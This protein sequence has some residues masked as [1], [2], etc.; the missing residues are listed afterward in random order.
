M[1]LLTTLAFT[2][3]ICSAFARQIPI[4]E[5]KEYAK[6]FLSSRSFVLTRGMNDAT[7]KDLNLIE[8][9]A[10]SSFHAFNIGE[11]KGFI[12]VS[13]L[14]DKPMV[15][16]YS[17]KGTFDFRN[18]PPQLRGILENTSDFK[19]ASSRFSTRSDVN[20]VLYQTAEWGQGAPYNNLCPDI[21][22]GKAQAGC[23]ATA[24]AIAMQYHQWPDYTQ[25]GKE[26]NYYHQDLIFDF[27]NYIPDWSSMADKN[28]PGFA[29]EV[30]KLTY[31]AGITAPM[32]YGL[33]ESSAEVW[34]ISHKMIY[35]YS[36]SKDC[37][38]IDKEV[39]NDEEWNAMLKK[40]LDEVGPVIYRGGKD[41]G[42]CFVI[43]GYNPEGFF[44]VNWGWD[45]ASNGYWALDFSDV[46]GL[47]FSEFQG[48][49]IN[50][51]PDRQHHQ[52]SR[53]FM[54]NAEVFMN[55]ETNVWNFSSTDIV[56][57]ERIQVKSPYI[58]LNKMIGY[59]TLGVVDEND[60]IIEILGEPQYWGRT[61][62]Q[63]LYCPFPGT[64]PL[65]YYVFP[66]LKDGQ[67]YQWVSLDVDCEPDVE[68]WNDLP[69]E[70]DPKD[71]KIILGGMIH[72]PYFYDK[73][74]FSHFVD[75]NYHISENA[76]VYMTWHNTVEKEFTSYRLWGGDAPENYIGAKGLTYKVTC[77]DMDGNPV[78]PLYVCNVENYGFS[79]NISVYQ[80]HYDVYIG[81]EDNGDTRHDKDLDPA[82]IAEQDGL[83][84]K[85]TDKGA[86]LIGY[87]KIGENVEV[88]AS[89]SVDGVQT[90]VRSIESIAL[91][92]A[93]IRDLTLNYSNLD[94]LKVMALACL[95]DIKRLSLDNYSDYL[96]DGLWREVSFPSFCLFLDSPIREVYCDKFPISDL[97]NYISGI[98]QTYD[99]NLRS[100]TTSVFNSNIDYYLSSDIDLNTTHWLYNSLSRLV[101]LK[102]ESGEDQ[103]VNSINIPGIGNNYD[104]PDFLNIDLPINQLWRYEIDKEKGLV[105]IGD[106][107][108]VV[109]IQSVRINGSDIVKNEEGLYEVPGYDGNSFEVVVNYKL[110]DY[111]DMTSTYTSDYNLSM[112]NSSLG[113]GVE[114]IFD[115]NSGNILDVYNLQGIPILK[116]VSPEVINSLD[117]GIYV[118]GGK[119][120]FVK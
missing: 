81:Y 103:I 48:M 80:H 6:D 98:K 90:P 82:Q 35:N 42:H 52:Y 25:G 41:P 50:I 56:P 83:V 21:D 69:E 55:P 34:P 32:I 114:R 47:D 84:Y 39:F 57:G 43:D 23:V 10:L 120:I 36:Y 86:A 61:N 77:T 118:I 13:A 71:W 93:P 68:F 100:P 28:N 15:L 104:V 27:D 70:T 1:R 30:A 109:D 99:S 8:D 46:G 5:A 62:D 44:H 66:G 74:N 117:P 79:T 73:G 9:N 116:N 12:L 14:G 101:S 59:F 3:G 76:P 113:A 31:S 60:N 53:M 89:I 19:E 75:I 29:D 72:K 115:N 2:M 38:Y 102:E 67:R 92:G 26:W 33:A 18:I 63:G 105:K 110:N 65:D 17:D 78:E 96:E 11:A 108:P 51:T 95:S 22:G 45:G 20:G 58:V 40:Q 119:K 85:L 7:F 87:D 49:I 94:S 111:K 64:D 91:K 24:M 4:E 16:G 54:P 107:Q 106:I 37:Q 112:I 88:P 97:F